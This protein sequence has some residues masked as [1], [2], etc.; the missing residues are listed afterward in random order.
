MDDFPVVKNTR[1]G[2]NVYVDG[3]WADE[4]YLCSDWQTVGKSKKPTHQLTFT[5]WDASQTD[6]KRVLKTFTFEKMQTSGE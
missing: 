1:F 2:A 6:D 5:G 3:H 4:S